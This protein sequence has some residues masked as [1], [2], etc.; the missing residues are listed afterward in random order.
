MIEEVSR[1]T[2][3]WL[4]MKKKKT[5]AMLTAYAKAGEI[6]ICEENIND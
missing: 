3:V 4:Q 5:K 2:Q 1:K 6:A